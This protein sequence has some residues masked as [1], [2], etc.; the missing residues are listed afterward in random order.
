MSA[1]WYSMCNILLVDTW[2]AASQRR[3]CFQQGWYDWLRSLGIAILLYKTTI[4]LLL[5]F[6]DFF[7]VIVP[8]NL[9]CY[10]VNAISLANLYCQLKLE[11]MFPATCLLTGKCMNIFH[12]IHYQLTNIDSNKFIIHNNLYLAFKQ[13]I[14]TF[15]MVQWSALPGFKN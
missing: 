14:C 10:V 6:L 1:S 4:F 12:Y 3:G 5:P 8:S 2:Q 11:L 15:L 9:V 13:S 7:N